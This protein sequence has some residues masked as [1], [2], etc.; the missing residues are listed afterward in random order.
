M[1]TNYVKMLAN[2]NLTSGQ[3]AISNVFVFPDLSQKCC[4]ESYDTIFDEFSKNVKT[5]T[6]SIE[7]KNLALSYISRMMK[8]DANSRLKAYWENQSDILNQEIREIEAQT[9]I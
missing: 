6:S 3:E 8:S 9:N 5:E 7:E 2:A 4:I 1:N